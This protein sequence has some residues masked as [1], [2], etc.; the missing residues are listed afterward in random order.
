[1]SKVE[2]GKSRVWYDTH[3]AICKKVF[4]PKEDRAKGHCTF[5]KD[6][7]ELDFLACL[8]CAK[9]AEI[10]VAVKQTKE[11]WQE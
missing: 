4:S 7:T 6:N 3:C 1:M 2:H 11:M 8:K 10:Q 5:K 9:E